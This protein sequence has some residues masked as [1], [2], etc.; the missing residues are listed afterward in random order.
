MR[1]LGVAVDFSPCSRA[2]LRWASDNLV[3]GGDR[4][5]VV[6]VNSCYQNEQGIVHLWE[7]TGSPFIPLNEFCDPT[8]GKKYGVAPDSETLEILRRMA[9]QKKVE[10]VAKIYYGDAKAMLCEAIDKI[11]LHYLVVGSRALSKLKRA[12]LGSV[13]S[14]VVSNAV[15]PVTVVKH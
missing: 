5:V 2:A 10:V 8:V 15:C 12:L 14:H 6:H 7:H 1:N 4:V 9:N 11:P 3:R 13:S